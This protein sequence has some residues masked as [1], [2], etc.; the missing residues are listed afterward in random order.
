MPQSATRE[1]RPGRFIV[2]EGGDGAGRSTQVRM[3]LAWLSD[4]GWPTCHA[5]IGRSRLAAEAFRQYKL[6]PATGPQS[7]ALLYAADLTAQAESTV[8]PALAA[9]F[10]V[11]ADR[12]TGTA[13]ARC[14]ARGLDGAY[15]ADIF[16]AG[17]E[18]DLVI[19]L[20]ARPRVRLERE[21]GR[22]GMPSVPESGRDMPASRDPLRSFLRYQGLLDRELRR[23]AAGGGWSTVSSLGDPRQVQQTLQRLVTRCL[24][25]GGGTDG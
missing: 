10:A 6:R 15:L 19:H 1:F 4:A 13:W 23:L 16:P 8:F 7:L 25:E 22:G 9:G 11:V 2:V 21:V 18:P 5:G 20:Y 24:G 3:L 14:R 12:W 17:P